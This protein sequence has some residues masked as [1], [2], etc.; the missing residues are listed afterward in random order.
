MLILFIDSLSQ[1]P[2]YAKFLKDILSKKRKVDEHEIIIL[3]E[4]CSTVILNKLP[5]K[6]E[7]PAIFSI[8]VSY[9]HLTLPTNR[10]V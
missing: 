5:T 6:L 8:A 10:E 9:T 4:E 3:G 2:L 7:D 1:I